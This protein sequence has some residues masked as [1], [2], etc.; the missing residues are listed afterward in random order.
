MAGITGRQHEFTPSNI[1]ETPSTIL[2]NDLGYCKT[3]AT[4]VSELLKPGIFQIGK[5]TISLC[6]TGSQQDHDLD[7]FLQVK[8]NPPLDIYLFFALKASDGYKSFSISW[9]MPPDADY[10]ETRAHDSYW[11]TIAGILMEYVLH[12][13]LERLCMKTSGIAKILVGGLNMEE[14][15]FT[16]SNITSLKSLTSLQMTQWVLDFPNYYQAM[17]ENT[18]SRIKKGIAGNRI[19]KIMA[20]VFAKRAP[21]EDDLPFFQVVHAAGLPEKGPFITFHPAHPLNPMRDCSKKTMAEI[22][23]YMRTYKIPMP[24]A[25]GSKNGLFKN[26]QVAQLNADPALTDGSLPSIAEFAAACTD[27]HSP[28]GWM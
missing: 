22:G 10:E 21:T 23:K 15:D 5:G 14:S 27:E 6:S 11:R 8:A 16:A 18:Q 26:N 9:G 17:S 24:G 20:Y 13:H 4:L 25:D 3:G 2:V 12:G 1:S 28:A 7:S 19:L